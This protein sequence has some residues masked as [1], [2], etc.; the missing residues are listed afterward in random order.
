[1]KKLI[2]IIS[3]GVLLSGCASAPKQ[4]D[5]KMLSDSHGE[6]QFPVQRAATGEKTFVFNPRKMAWAAYDETGYRVKTGPASGGVDECPEDGENC[7]TVTGDFR[8]TR[9]GD[10]SCTSKTYPGEDGGPA[11]MKY[12]MFFHKGYAIHGANGIPTVH[13]SHG[14]IRVKVHHARWLNKEFLNV[15]SRVVVEEY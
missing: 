14:C 8:V 7:R 15:G 10:S 4:W 1:M 12:C 6:R 2:A 13:S 11:P 9:K 5:G 3:L